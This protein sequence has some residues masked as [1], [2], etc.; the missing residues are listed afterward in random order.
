ML[1][2]RAAPPKRITT[3][4]NTKRSRFL[5]PLVALSVITLHLTVFSLGTFEVTLGVLLGVP[6]LLLSVRCIPF[7][8]LTFATS[9]IILITGVVA[10]TSPLSSPGDYFGTLALVLAATGIIT[11]STA[12]EWNPGLRECFRKGLLLALIMV[13][14]ISV[15]QTV[16]GYY[17]F[18][19]LFNVWG[20]RQYLYAYN[21]GLQ[22]VAIPRAQG[23]YLEPSYNAFVILALCVSLFF[24]GENR[25]YAVV[26]GVVGLIV[27]QSTTGLLVAIAIGA[28]TAMKSGARARTSALLVLAGVLVATLGTILERLASIQSLGSSASYRITQPLPVLEDVLSTAPAGMPLGSVYSVIR[29]YELLMDGQIQATT[30]DNGV[31]VLVYYFGWLAVAAIL[32]GITLFAVELGR[33]SSLSPLRTAFIMLLFCSLLFSGAIMAIDF[34]LL[35]AVCTVSFRMGTSVESGQYG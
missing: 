28:V 31:Y 32:A 20:E 7:V 18:D 8:A 12:A 4:P 2:R 14:G 3:T 26:I 27:T 22:W 23:F 17:D 33:R 1:L 35:I 10:L 13:C 15:G 19:Y 11:L 5:I 30:L 34:A 25:K 9:L 21:P 16:T 24:L 29:E 6:L